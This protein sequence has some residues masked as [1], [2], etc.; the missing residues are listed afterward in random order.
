MKV[1]YGNSVAAAGSHPVFGAWD[2]HK[3]AAMTWTEGHVWTADLSLPVGSKVEYKFIIRKRHDGVD[4]APGGNHVFTVPED[5]LTAEV[6]DAWGHAGA[7]LKVTQVRKQEAPSP[8]APE[9]VATVQDAT[10]A[11]AT[12][13]AATASSNGSS[14]TQAS[15]LAP[16]ATA[17]APKSAAAVAPSP[18]AS[19]PNGSSPASPDSN[20]SSP[21]TP[22]SEPPS[23][24]GIVAN[25][26]VSPVGLNLSP[27]DSFSSNGNGNGSVSSG[28]R[29]PRGTYASY[30]EHSGSEMQV[31]E[32]HSSA[33]TL[34]PP[35]E[36]EAPI[37][38]PDLAELQV[39]QLKRM[40]VTDLRSN[41]RR[42]NLSVLGTKPELVARL[43]QALETK[44]AGEQDPHLNKWSTAQM[45]GELKKRGMPTTG[46]RA[47]LI[48]R[49][50][51]VGGA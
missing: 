31:F 20:G 33:A 35:Q 50:R 4:W 26:I 34:A 44:A 29:S 17:A 49:L 1:D 48:Q 11:V 43:S 42:L 46:N 14:P 12:A 18:S 40:T 19:S 23:L 5:A 30:D 24:S 39:Q 28:G 47:Q 25:N 38:L 27:L 37:T 9:P 15:G 21:A 3:A 22:R 41:L 6:L 2:P 13:T 51:E 16:A 7:A 8:P 32:V 45:R 10:A 36:D